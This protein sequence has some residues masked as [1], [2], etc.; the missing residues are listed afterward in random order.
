MLGQGKAKTEGTIWTPLFINVFL[1]NFLVH[2]CSQM[3]NTLTSKYAAYLGAPSTI[4]GVVAGMYAYTALLFKMVSAPAID[5]F[6]RKYVLLAADFVIF[7]SFVGYA[8][9]DSISM[10]MVSRLLQGSG[11]AF[12][13]TCCLT[14]ASESL[15]N[16]KMS[17]GIGYFALAT[18][19]AQA[20]GPTI[21][22]NLAQMIGYNRTFA[23]MAG[24]MAVAMTLVSMLK[25]KFVK[26]KKFVI[27]LKTI[28]AK[29]C[30]IPSA[31]LFMLAVAYCVVNSFLVLYAE[32]RGIGSGIGYFFTVYAVT[33][34]FSRPFI[35]KMADKY[36]AVRVM[37]PSMCCFAAAFLLISVSTSLPMFLAAAFISAF[38][39]GGCQPTIQAVNMRSVPKERRGA[40]SCTSFIGQD[41]GAMLGPMAAGAAVEMFGYVNMWR[42]MILPIVLAMAATIIFRGRIDHGGEQAG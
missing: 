1:V 36:G 32:S 25:I 9:S 16:E 13:T 41:C 6:N 4:V 40:A 28:I 17:S 15:P 21:G 20:I 19:L 3:M 11:L 7:L 24:I 35:G 34:L 39:Y 23:V 12:T 30:I 27:S 8:L 14:I 22:L 33:M 5:T 31:I 42:V 2:C 26:T 18:A 10:L 37:I 38:G 29:E